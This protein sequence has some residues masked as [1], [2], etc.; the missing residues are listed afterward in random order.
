[1]QGTY[2]FNVECAEMSQSGSALKYF[3]VVVC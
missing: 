1:M 3:K 2:K